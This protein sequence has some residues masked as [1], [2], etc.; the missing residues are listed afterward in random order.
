MQA[1]IQKRREKQNDELERV[2]SWCKR[3][4]NAW[5][6]I[7]NDDPKAVGRFLLSS[8]FLLPRD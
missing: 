3:K 7:L 8:R 5:T 6:L 4:K 1:G 2:K